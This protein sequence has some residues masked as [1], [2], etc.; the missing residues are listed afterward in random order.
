MAWNPRW[1]LFT[2]CEAGLRPA[3]LNTVFARK[4]WSKKAYS[5]T[6]NP[7]GA[8]AASLKMVN[9]LKNWNGTIPNEL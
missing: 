3:K 2:F 1:S 5:H 9:S 6:F 7:F 4:N 8:L